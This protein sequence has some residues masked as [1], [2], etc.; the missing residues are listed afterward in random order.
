M[1][2]PTTYLK[3]M[4]YKQRL[5]TLKLPTLSYRRLRGDM[6]EVYKIIKGVYDKEAASFLKM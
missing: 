2:T 4:S 5:K 3:D 6:I 1:H